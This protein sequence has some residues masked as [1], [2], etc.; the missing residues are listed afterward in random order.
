MR[1]IKKLRNKQKKVVA[2]AKEKAYEELYKKLN[3]K[4]RAND[5]F[6]IA[7][8]RERRRKDLEDICFIRDERGR[9]ITDEEEIKKIRGEYFS[10]L[11]N[12]RE[13]EGCEE[14]VDPI[15]LSQFVGY[16]SRISHEK[17]RTALQ[18]MGEK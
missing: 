16:Y 15:I 3:S 2:Q 14:V 18:K 12:A 10:S 7:K 13:P 17:V 11:F 1:G 8:A 4:E 9:T 6:K 5:I